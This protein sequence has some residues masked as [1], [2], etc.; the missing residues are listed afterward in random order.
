MSAGGQFIWDNMVKR[1]KRCAACD[2]GHQMA[3]SK[4]TRPCKR[5]DSMFLVQRGRM[6]NYFC[7]AGIHQASLSI[8]VSIVPFYA[9]IAV[10]LIGGKDLRPATPPSPADNSRHEP[11]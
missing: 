6:R 5:R 8:S 7:L 2:F 1:Q 9:L 3:G 4:D 11:V 10:S